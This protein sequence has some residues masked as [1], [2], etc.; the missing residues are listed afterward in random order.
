VVQKLEVEE[1]TVLVMVKVVD[2]LLDL[3][4]QEITPTE[5]VEDMDQVQKVVD[6]RQ[7]WVL[8][9]ERG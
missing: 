4:A 9:E 7:E 1:D 5:V 6:L 2:L 8:E 3:V